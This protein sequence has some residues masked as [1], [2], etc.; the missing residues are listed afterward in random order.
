MNYISI[1]RGLIELT[2]K[3][4]SHCKIAKANPSL[5]LN[6]RVK[7]M[8]HTEDIKYKLYLNDLFVMTAPKRVLLSKVCFLRERIEAD[9]SATPNIVHLL[10]NI[11]NWPVELAFGQNPLIFTPPDLYHFYKGHETLGCLEESAHFKA[12]FMILICPTAFLLLS[13][14]VILSLTKALPPHAWPA[15]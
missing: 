15:G 8:C 5:E 4:L 3:H 9:C 7:M 6:K 11:T 12:C 2:F 1:V 10:L 13:A 14:Y